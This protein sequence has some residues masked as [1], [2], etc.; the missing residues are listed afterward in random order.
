[1]NKTK[2]SVAVIFTLALLTACKNQQ[3][4]NPETTNDLAM[5]INDFVSFKLTTD[6]QKLSENQKKMLPLLFEAAKLMED[7]FMKSI[8]DFF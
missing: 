1:M 8:L 4:E 5:K 2:L 7:I 6:L 3:K